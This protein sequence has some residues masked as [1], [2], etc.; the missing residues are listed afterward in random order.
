VVVGLDTVVRVLDVVG[1][2]GVGAV[3][4]GGVG[5]GGGFGVPSVV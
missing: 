5:V 4:V 3:G 2:V 1:V